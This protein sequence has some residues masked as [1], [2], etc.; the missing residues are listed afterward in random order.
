M[1]V[2]SSFSMIEPHSAEAALDRAYSDGQIVG[3]FGLA[4]SAGCPFGGNQLDLRIAWLDGFAY[5]VWAGA[6]KAADGNADEIT[7]PAPEPVPER[8]NRAIA[9]IAIAHLF[10]LSRR[11][12]SDGEPMEAFAP[13]LEAAAAFS[14][15]VKLTRPDQTGQA[16]AEDK[17]A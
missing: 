5:G 1:A 12:G 10:R 2:H 17:A 4:T 13:A 9:D 14:L 8:G 7:R 15:L 11:I 16:G 6:A 3:F